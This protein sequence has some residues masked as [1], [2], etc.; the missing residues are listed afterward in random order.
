MKS[1]YGSVTVTIKDFYPKSMTIYNSAND[2]YLD[3]YRVR[4]FDNGTCFLNVRKT[5]LPY[6]TTSNI[7]IP[8]FE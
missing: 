4:F 6:Q 3:S 5:N 8:T 7:R 2:R 1:D